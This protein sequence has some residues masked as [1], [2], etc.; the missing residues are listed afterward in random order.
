MTT[1]FSTWDAC[2]HRGSS[3][4]GSSD[5]VAVVVEAVMVE[6]VVKCSI[7]CRNG[8]SSRGISG[9]THNKNTQGTVTVKQLG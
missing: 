8:S 1:R 5:S 6:G 9:I 3:S 7:S 4:R 2:G